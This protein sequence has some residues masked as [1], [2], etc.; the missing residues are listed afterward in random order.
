[1][2]SSRSVNEPLLALEIVALV[3]LEGTVAVLRV[4]GPCVAVRGEH[5]VGGS[6]RR[7]DARHSRAVQNPDIKIN[8]CLIFC[9]VCMLYLLKLHPYITHRCGIKVKLCL[10]TVYEEP[11][12]SFNSTVSGMD[13]CILT[14]YC[15]HTCCTGR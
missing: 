8:T 11:F 10:L 4:V 6:G 1:M 5:G 12:G 2:V 13:R 7:S 14:D 3:S 9:L 15:R